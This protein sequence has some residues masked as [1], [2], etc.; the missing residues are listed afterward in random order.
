MK[1]KTKIVCTIGP[2]TENCEMLEKMIQAGMNVARIN[3]SHGNY[4]EYA[5]KIK[6]VHQVAEKL[7]TFVGVMLDTKGPEI[8][9]GYFENGMQQYKQGDCVYLVKEKC[10]GNQERFQVCCEEL[11]NDIQVGNTILIDDGKIILSVLECD[12]DKIYCEFKNPAI[13][14]DRKGINVPG[15]TLS[16]PFISKQDYQDIEFACS[17][18]VDTLALSFVR[19]KEDVLAVKELLR[20]FNRPDIDIIAKIESQEG[21]DNLKEILEVANGIMV[22]RGDLGVEVLPEKVPLYQK[23]MIKIANQ[24]GKVVITATHML[25]SMISNPRPTRAE[26]NDV[27]NAIFDGTD[28]IMLSGESAI[29]K[30]PV[31]S[32]QMMDKIALSVE[33]VLDYRSD[34]FRALKSSQRTKNDAIG[35]SVTE[36]CLTLENVSAIFAFTQTGGTAKRI[37]KFRPNVPIIACSDSI[38]TCQKMCYY[39]GVYPTIAKYENDLVKW[40]EEAQRVA[41]EFD[42]KLKTTIILTSGVGQKHGSTNTI[43][44]IEVE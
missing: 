14:K 17:Q 39:W 1:R 38:T 6:N 26:V 22:A 20:K 27:A 18:K 2:A 42:L 5:Q 25:E 29:G 12:A 21:M 7:N 24:M 31:E 23:E 36:C 33:E 41:K 3:C 40:D 15:V 30:Y 10:M 28:A 9:C 35:I 16:M 44:I 32:V 8:R 19:R 43:R 34:L 37:R 13:V 4:E 11:F